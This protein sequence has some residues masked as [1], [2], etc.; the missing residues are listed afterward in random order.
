MD[1]QS[2]QIASVQT[3]YLN[4]HI[5]CQKKKK[6]TQNK[7]LSWHV[8]CHRAKFGGPALLRG[9]LPC[10]PLVHKNVGSKLA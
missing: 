3:F 1:L 4:T 2:L 7:Q 9:E 6:K 10:Q 8:N 5:K